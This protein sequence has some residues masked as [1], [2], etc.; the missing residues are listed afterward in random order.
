MKQFRKISRMALATAAC[1]M[2]LLSVAPDFTMQAGAC[3][4]HRLRDDFPSGRR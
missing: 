1:S 2:A 4:I 3:G